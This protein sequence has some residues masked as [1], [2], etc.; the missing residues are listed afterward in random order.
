VKSKPYLKPS[1]EITSLKL[2]ENVIRNTTVRRIAGVFPIGY[3]KTVTKEGYSF[4]DF[5]KV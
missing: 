4:Y 2:I 3:V 5:R 1:N